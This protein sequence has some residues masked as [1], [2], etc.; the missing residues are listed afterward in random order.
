MTAFDARPVELHLVESILINEVEATAFVH[1]HFS[2]PETVDNGVE[3][4]CGRCLV[5]IGAWIALLVEGDR[6]AYPWLCSRHLIYLAE[7]TKSVFPF[8]V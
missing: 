7:L 8:I 3:D 2:Q 5:V 6:R 4:Q 1:E